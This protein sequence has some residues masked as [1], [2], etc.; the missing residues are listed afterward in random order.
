MVNDAG[1]RIK[2]PQKIREL[3]AQR[4]GYRCS[5]PGCGQLTIGPAKDPDKAATN[6]TASHIYCAAVSGK[7]PR[8]TGGL[9]ENDLKSA[10]N[11]IWL[12]GHHA[13]L[14]DEH[15]GED[16]SA[17]ILHSYKALHETRVAY[18]HAG[19]HAP[20][21]WVDSVKVD[22]CPLFSEKFEFKFAKLNLIIGGNSVG[23]TALCEWIATNFNPIYLERWEKIIPEK[24]KRVSSEIRY[25][26]PN[27]HCIN[28]E[29]LS[30]DY[31]RYKLDRKSMFVSIDPVK[32]IFPAEIQFGNQ[33]EQ[34]DLALVANALNLHPYEVKALCDNIGT[35]SDYFEKAWF[36]ENKEGCYMYV[37]VQNTTPSNP[38]QL[39]LLSDS[40][41][42]ILLMQLGMIAADKLSVMGPT[43]LILDSGF[44]R[45]DTNWLRR[46]A[47]ILGSPTCRFQTIASTRLSN[48]NFDDLTWAGWKI[49]RLEGE[50]PEVVMSVGVGARNC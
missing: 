9:S 20:F 6:G 8:G 2:F 17:D 44:N 38:R 31:P 32:V 25:H 21:G 27:P 23:K 36:K 11:A 48:I 19:I 5:F 18:E 42:A 40:E 49:I 34:N 22:S 3:V 26:N 43:L 13:S 7:G 35:N 14:I 33:E 39:R 15:H 24:Q 47:N 10:Q 37:Q 46:Y 12:C 1:R 28:V 30:E 50:P 29:F 4:A 41:R 45:F 16:Y